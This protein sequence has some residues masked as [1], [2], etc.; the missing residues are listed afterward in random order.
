MNL[1]IHGCPGD[2]VIGFV[3]CMI[4]TRLLRWARQNI[5]WLR[6]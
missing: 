2:M 4:V 3:A 5:G 1:P 6:R